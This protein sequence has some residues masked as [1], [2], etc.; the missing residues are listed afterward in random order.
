M[1]RVVTGPSMLALALAAACGGG[2][3]G[4]EGRSEAE[5]RREAEAL[6]VEEL[7]ERLDELEAEFDRVLKDMTARAA[8][9]EKAAAEELSGR[10]DALR[11]AVKVYGEVLAEKEAGG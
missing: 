6:D 7:Q 1:R 3:S 8:A 5:L 2:S 4:V 11:A 9:M 10:M